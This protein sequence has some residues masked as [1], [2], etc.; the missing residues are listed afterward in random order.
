ML[1]IC[2]YYF[3]F[4]EELEHPQILYFQEVLAPTLTDTQ[5]KDCTDLYVKDNHCLSVRTFRVPQ[6]LNPVQ[7]ALPPLST[8]VS[9]KAWISTLTCTDPLQQKWFLSFFSSQ[10]DEIPGDGCCDEC[11]IIES[12]GWLFSV[13]FLGFFI[14][15]NLS[16]AGF[17]VNCVQ[18][19]H[20]QHSYQRGSV[21]N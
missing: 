5:R 2:K 17:S 19:G 14:L 7:T 10:P 6:C 9:G 4:C 8:V 12:C 16:G 3:S 20:S 18:S 13:C 11:V 1:V 21:F 15:G